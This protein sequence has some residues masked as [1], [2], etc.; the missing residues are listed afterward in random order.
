MTIS[1]TFPMSIEMSGTMGQSDAGTTVLTN[2]GFEL[3]G[4]FWPG[5]VSSAVFM[6]RADQ[7]FDEDVDGVDFAVFASC[8]N[9][10]GNPPRTLGCPQN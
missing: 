4:G 7:E 9:K 1:K 8:F 3:A 5:V 10:T 2:S 6:V